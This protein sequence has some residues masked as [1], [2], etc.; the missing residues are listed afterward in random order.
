[1]SRRW[2]L[3]GAAA[4]SLVFAPVKLLISRALP[5]CSFRADPTTPSLSCH[6]RLACHRHGMA[7]DF[8]RRLTGVTTE[9]SNAGW[10]DWGHDDAGGLRGGLVPALWT[11]QPLPLYDPFIAL[12]LMLVALDGLGFHV[13]L[14][15]LPRR[16]CCWR[17]DPPTFKAFGRLGPLESETTN[18]LNTGNKLGRKI[19]GPVGILL[20]RRM[21]A[22]I[23]VTVQN[24]FAQR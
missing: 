3:V 14:L 24:V 13:S 15:P 19:L 8:P 4:L 17:Y 16:C 20:G 1:M 7:G 5:G 9:L 22:E 10:S 18:G 12:G 11:H 2:S 23:Q 21:V 6:H